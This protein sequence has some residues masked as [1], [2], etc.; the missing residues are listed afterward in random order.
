MKSARGVFSLVVLG[1]GLALAGTP[2][3]ATVL[4]DNLSASITA[5]DFVS[6]FG[7]ADSFSTGGSAVSLTDLKVMVSGDPASTGDVSI[8]L[9]ADNSTS[10]GG[11]IATLGGI[12]A[13]SLGTD[14]VYDFALVS[15]IALVPDT[16]YWIELMTSN[17]SVTWPWSLDVS[18]TGVGSEFYANADGVFPNEFGPYLMQVNAVPEPAAISLIGISILALGILRRS[19][20]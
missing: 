16:R 7:L 8:S 2:A 1:A 15:P 17:D 6:S 20:A 18:G 14:V 5:E 11:L 19:K 13:G 10:P 9:L 3:S 4:Y 12:V